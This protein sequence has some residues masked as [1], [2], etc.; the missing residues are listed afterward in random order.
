MKFDTKIVVQILT[1]LFIIYFLYRAYTYLGD[2]KSC[3]CA[4]TVYANRLKILEGIYISL[5]GIGI[6]TVVF[7]TTLMK[8]VQMSGSTMTSIFVVALLSVYL[9]FIY[10]AYQFQKNIDENC[11][12]DK[13]WERMVIYIQAVLYAIPFIFV[14]LGLLFGSGNIALLL[15]IIISI[16]IDMIYFQKKLV[17][18][19]T[20]IIPVLTQ[21]LSKV[22]DVLLNAPMPTN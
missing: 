22:P 8:M 6:I 1:S 4:P 21:G 20:T 10:N 7:S 3:G 11:E 12:C 13:K 18:S 15:A 19:S 5:Y 9:M 2:L 17:V 16:S 14:L